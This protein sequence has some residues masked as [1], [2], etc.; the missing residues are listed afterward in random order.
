V[1]ESNWTIQSL[2]EHFESVLAEREKRRDEQ[3]HSTLL[4]LKKAEDALEHRL[5]RLNEFRAQAIAERSMFVT[6][7]EFEALEKRYE[8]R[9]SELEI[10]VRLLQARVVP[11]I[12]VGST[13][14]IA[15]VAA[16]IS[17]IIT[18]TP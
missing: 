6:H 11:I 8:Q 1:G 18:G 3:N 17:H 4:A 5:E 14:V 16:F 7:E 10:D 2:K 13:L 15:V 12:W 9:H